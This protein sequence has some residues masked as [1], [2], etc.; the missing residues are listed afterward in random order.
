MC[1]FS[2]EDNQLLESAQP[3]HYTSSLGFKFYAFTKGKERYFPT[4]LSNNHI[5]HDRGGHV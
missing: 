2:G 4:Y 5:V 1:D 3:Y